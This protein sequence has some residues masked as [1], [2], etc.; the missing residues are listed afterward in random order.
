MSTR[1]FHAG[2]F[3]SLLFTASLAR[4]ESAMDGLKQQVIE[5]ER[6]F[7]ATMAARDHAAFVTFLA[8]EAVFFSGDTPLRGREAVAEAWRPYF[9]GEAAPFSWEPVT[10]EVLAS[11][12]LALSS[13]P[14][15]NPEGEVVG[16]FN[17]IWRL[18]EDG[19][20]RIVFDKGGEVCSRGD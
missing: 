15:R 6:A 7:A 17:S 1:F 5:R 19:Q 14:V 13:G 20:W 3:A 10:V 8:G 11:G 4:G 18:A 2:V 12:A 9:D 16:V